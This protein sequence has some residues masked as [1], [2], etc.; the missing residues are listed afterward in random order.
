[1]TAFSRPGHCC[2]TCSSETIL[3]ADRPHPR[4]PATMYRS[5]LC[6][7]CDRDDPAA[8]GLLAFFA[9]HPVIDST[10]FDTFRVLAQE[11]LDRLPDPPLVSEQDFD[12]DVEAWRRGDFDGP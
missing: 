9:V 4:F 2:P 7:I 6:P 3:A 10:T 12:A 8:S 1:M 5:Y 11:W